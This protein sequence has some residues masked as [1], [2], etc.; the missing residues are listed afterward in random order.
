MFRSFVK[1]VHEL[2]WHCVVFRESLKHR[3]APYCSSTHVID[4]SVLVHFA[5]DLRFTCETVVSTR[6]KRS[7]QQ[8]SI[9]ARIDARDNERASDF[10]QK[11]MD[12]VLVALGRC[13]KHV[14]VKSTFSHGTTYTSEFVHV[15]ATSTPCI[16]HVIL[17]G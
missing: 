10:I 5:R 12:H 16:K 14:A 2:Q 6:P 4:T 8:R 3:A 11:L 9:N 7:R 1:N 17:V 13:S 15:I